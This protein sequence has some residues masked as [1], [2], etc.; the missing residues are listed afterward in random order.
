MRNKDKKGLS[1]AVMKE[2]VDEEETGAVDKRGL[3]EVVTE[4]E[5]DKKRAGVVEPE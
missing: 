5:V 1:E 4:E 3:A 2:E